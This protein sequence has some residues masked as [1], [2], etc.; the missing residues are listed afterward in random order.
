MRN[1]IWRVG[2]VGLLLTQIPWLNFV[3]PARAQADAS[4]KPDQLLVQAG[5]QTLAGRNLDELMAIYNW[6]LEAPLSAEEQASLGVVL[7]DEFKANPTRVAKNYAAIHEQLPQIL[8]ADPLQQARRRAEI[9][10]HLIKDAPNEPSTQAVLKILAGNR[11][12]LLVTDKGVVTQ[13]EI[14]ALIASDDNV[15]AVAGLAKNSPA[16]RAHITRMIVADFPGFKEN[17]V[18]YEAVA[19]DEERCLSL[20]AFVESSAQNRAAVIAEIRVKVHDPADIP[21]EARALENNALLLTRMGR[22]VL[23]QKII[24]GVVAVYNGQIN[25]IREAGDRYMWY[26]SRAYQPGEAKPGSHTGLG[27]D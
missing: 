4:S 3:H 21:R 24:S 27:P 15:A 14:D 5:G 13:P 17:E 6:L 1:L 10:K 8:H 25:T 23:Q 20:R 22:Y 9:W 18:R 19:D 2:I 7:I 11:S 12:V 26:E 16:E